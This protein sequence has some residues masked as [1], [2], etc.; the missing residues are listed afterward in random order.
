M[1]ENNVPETREVAHRWYCHTCES[2]TEPL[3][4]VSMLYCCYVMYKSC[5]R[6]TWR[7]QSL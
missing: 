3:L 7:L 4:A 1:A 5:Q 2:E 6:T